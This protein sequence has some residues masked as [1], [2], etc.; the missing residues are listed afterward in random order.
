MPLPFSVAQAQ[1]RERAIPR[2]LASTCVPARHARRATPPAGSPPHSDPPTA[3]RGHPAHA[4]AP[5]RRPSQLADAGLRDRGRIARV[6]DT[7]A[8]PGWF[9][10]DATTQADRRLQD[11]L[12]Q[13]RAY[14]ASAANYRPPD[15]YVR[16]PA[17]QAGQGYT[18]ACGPASTPAH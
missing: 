2:P 15:R 1:T 18:P 7:P 13:W 11:R 17:A 8:F 9:V 3:P 5:T 14:P 6:G 12:T 4:S 16:R 10:E